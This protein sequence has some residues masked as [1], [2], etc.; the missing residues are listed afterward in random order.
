M[1]TM[2]QNAVARSLKF[3]S[4]RIRRHSKDD[5]DIV[6]S[7]LDTLDQK[8]NEIAPRRPINLIQPI[9]DRPRE[10]LELANDHRQSCPEISHVQRGFPLLLQG[11]DALLEVRHTGFEVILLDDTIG[12]AVDQASHA[13][14]QAARRLSIA[15]TVC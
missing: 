13:A 3:W 9:A 15:V 5:V 12:V 10:S 11:I 7:D 6:F 1:W 8:A 4:L 14:T 2:L